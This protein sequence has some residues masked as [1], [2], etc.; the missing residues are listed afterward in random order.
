MKKRVLGVVLTLVLALGC[1]FAVMG[2]GSDAKDLYDYAKSTSTP[3][4]SATKIDELD[5]YVYGNSAEGNLAVF[6]KYD[7]ESSST[8]YKVFNLDTGKVVATMTIAEGADGGYYLFEVE[9]VG[10]A[11][12]CSYYKAANASVYTYKLFSENGTEITNFSK[13]GELTENILKIKLDLIEFNDIIYRVGTDGSVVKAFDVND[14]SKFE[15]TELD[16]KSEN[17]YYDAKEGVI[18]V[19][20]AV[21]GTPVSYYQVPSYAEGFN[22]HV[23]SNGN[24]FVQYSVKVDPYTD[25]Y[26]YLKETQNGIAKYT[27]EQKIVNPKNGDVKDVKNSKN[28]VYIE[29]VVA[30]SGV[31]AQNYTFTTDEYKGSA[32]NFASVQKIEDK[33]INTSTD[34]NYFMSDKGKLSE[35]EDTIVAQEGTGAGLDNGYVIFTNKLGQAFLYDAELNLVG[36]VT[37]AKKYTEK[38]IITE[39]AIYDYTLKKVIDFAIGG[40]D[41]NYSIGGYSIVGENIIVRKEVKTE[42][43]SYYDYY[44]LKDSN[45][46]TLIGTT[47]STGTVIFTKTIGKCIVT[48]SAADSKYSLCNEDG[49]VLASNL[50]ST[51]YSVGNLNAIVKTGNS[52]YFVK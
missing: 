23:L 29:Y 37:N 7:S 1:A 49:T 24:I 44:L 31:I 15:I 16:A 28:P 2:C 12:F 39:K 9:K 18:V 19:Y 43:S 4:S 27:L 52:Y 17:Y 42:N 46:P 41:I 22:C 36:E 8:S 21:D 25:K 34:Y 50:E 32:K 6:S 48:R 47:N 13:S 30:L 51:P 3:Y 14:L 26:D 38:F 40:Y 11:V 5:K 33:K 45:A 20:S 10:G 35:I